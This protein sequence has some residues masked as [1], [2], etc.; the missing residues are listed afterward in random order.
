MARRKQRSPI[1]RRAFENVVST[2]VFLGAAKDGVC[3]VLTFS[4]PVVLDAWS[5][6]GLTIDD[7]F[8]LTTASE[9]TYIGNTVR[10]CP[11][12]CEVFVGPDGGFVSGSF[13]GADLKPVPVP[14]FVF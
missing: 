5:Q 7:C 3:V 4:C 1:P 12:D 10:V 14:N 8:S 9:V 6:V 2:C 11:A 13:Y